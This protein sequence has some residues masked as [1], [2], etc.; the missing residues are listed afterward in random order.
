MAQQC[1]L[2]STPYLRQEFGQV[3]IHDGL[4]Q[5]HR[6]ILLRILQFEVSCCRQHRLDSPH[7]IVVVVLGGQQFRAQS[8]GGYNLS[9]QG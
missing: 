5:Q 3:D 6:L 9:V 1:H 7:T 8:V 2:P 4:E